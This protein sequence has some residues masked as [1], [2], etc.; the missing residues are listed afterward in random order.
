MLE[1]VSVLAHSEVNTIMIGGELDYGR[2]GM[3]G[4]L[5]YEMLKRFRFDQ[6][7][8]GVV[9]VNLDENE[10]TTYMANEGMTKRLVV[11]HAKER[12]M[13]CEVEKL[14]EEGNYKFADVSEFTG[15]ILGYPISKE[16]KA[17]FQELN[18]EVFD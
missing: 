17:Q 15:C 2:D 7:F 18:V 11:Q 16:R 12:Y 14:N 5:A 1:V 9:G 4:T 3:I 6:A 13:L 8:V 10:V